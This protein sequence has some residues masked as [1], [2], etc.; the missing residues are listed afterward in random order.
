MNP[1]SLGA[2]SVS[3][4]RGSSLRRRLRLPPE[5]C[6]RALRATLL[7]R[8][9]TESRDAWPGRSECPASLHGT[10]TRLFARRRV[11]VRLFGL[12]FQP[13]QVLGEVRDRWRRR[14]HLRVRCRRIHHVDWN[15]TFS[16]A[17][18]GADLCPTLDV[19]TTQ[20]DR[21]ARKRFNHPENDPRASSRVM[22]S[23]GLATSMP[24]A[25]MIS[26]S[27]MNRRP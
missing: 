19:M 10:N 12:D 7:P 17:N 3:E 25:P 16:V 26:R 8:A 23:I 2:I 24:W 21:R 5:S 18:G 1:D 4:R 13:P 20:R 27:S 22:Y 9:R 6:A 15:N 11:S 14:R